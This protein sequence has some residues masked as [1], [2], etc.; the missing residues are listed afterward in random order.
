MN[1]AFASLR[2]AGTALARRAAARAVPVT[3]MRQM[4]GASPVL[5]TA[6]NTIWRRNATYM[7]YVI[8]GAVVCE[9]IYGKLTDSIWEAANSGK[10]YHHIDWTKFK[11]DDDEDEDDE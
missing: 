11:T 9:M 3:A 10:M 5:K 2:P 7:L 4:S 8:G 1:S 6:Y